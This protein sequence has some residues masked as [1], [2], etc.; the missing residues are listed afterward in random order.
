MPS[1]WALLVGRFAPLGRPTGRRLAKICT[2]QP[3]TQ[4]RS[5]CCDCPP[6][7]AID[8]A[9]AETSPKELSCVPAKPVDTVGGPL[10]TLGAPH[11][12]PPGQICTNQP[13]TPRRSSCCDCP[14]ST[15][16][17]AAA[18]ETSP[19]ELPRGMSYRGPLL[20]LSSNLERFVRCP[21]DWCT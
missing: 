6:S 2:K 16:I 17:D 19:T 8:A 7:T 4:R 9:A 21:E 12:P 13:D 14:S 5:S 15:A 11:G 18:V 10:G 20:S 3:D 1:P